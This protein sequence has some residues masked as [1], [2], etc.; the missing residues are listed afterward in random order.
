MVRMKIRVCLLPRLIN[1]S[2][3][4]FQ[5]T[6]SVETSQ[7]SILG[8]ISVLVRNQTR[9]HY[10]NF[11]YWLHIQDAR[12]SLFEP[13]HL[14]HIEGRLAVLQQKMNDVAEKKQAREEQVRVQALNL[15]RVSS[16][17][18]WLPICH[19][20]RTSRVVYLSFTTLSKR[21]K[22]WAKHCQRSWTG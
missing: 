13:S 7:K 10:A 5:S 2:C 12:T 4:K 8:A 17:P 1:F 9:M 14:A 15:L 21:A 22:G 11:I 19:L 3:S 6:L 16:V 18:F 20:S